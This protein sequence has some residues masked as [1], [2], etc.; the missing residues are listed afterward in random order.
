MLIGY[1]ENN[2]RHPILARFIRYLFVA[3]SQSYQCCLGGQSRDPGER[4]GG[5][6]VGRAEQQ[7]GA[8][9]QVH[10]DLRPRAPEPQEVLRPQRHLPL[11]GRGMVSN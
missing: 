2:N 3:R 5:A 11:P 1:T 9:A 4:R 8:H 6:G 7:R 10:A